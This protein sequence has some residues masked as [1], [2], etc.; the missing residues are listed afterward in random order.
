MCQNSVLLHPVTFTIS[1]SQH[2]AASSDNTSEKKLLHTSKG[3]GEERE[4]RARNITET[5]TMVKRIC[6]IGAGVSGLASTKSCLDE[7][8]EPTCFDMGDDIGGLWKYHAK[9]V[10]DR[11]SVFRSLVTNISKEM[12]C[13]S[14]HPMPSHYPTYLGHA[15][16]LKYL[17]LYAENFKLN[18]HIRLKTKVEAVTKRPDFTSSGQWDVVVVDENGKK[19][20]MVFDAIIVCSGH[21]YAANIPKDSFPGI[22][23]FK[24]QIIHS[25]DYR[26]PS[27]Y[28]GKRV[29]VIGFGNSG[30]DISTEIS[31]HASQVFMSTR[32][33]AWVLD[34]VA[35]NGYPFDMMIIRRSI[36]VLRHWLP[37]EW[38][39]RYEERKLNF[40]FNHVNFGVTPNFRLYSKQVTINDDVPHR[41]ILGKMIMKPNVASFTDNGV[42]FVDGSRA[43]NLDAVVFATGYHFRFPFLEVDGTLTVHQNKNNFYKNMFLPKLPKQTLALI[44]LVEP[45]GPVPALVEMQSRFVTQVFKGLVSLPEE[46]EMLKDISDKQEEH[47]KKYVILQNMHHKANLFGG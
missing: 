39:L 21:N 3:G 38:M 24:G 11:G 4:G 9:I 34:R 35:D 17:H 30:A 12:M 47:A 43:E 13:Y 23:K 19:E 7:G 36:N 6:V 32:D 14:D 8:L 28:T 40:K 10:E 45:N 31:R 26:E 41:I 16:M 37:F 46:S 42:V 2:V 27:P 20:E 44:G 29:L 33:G 1:A 25:K 5:V 18:N 15:D 22:E